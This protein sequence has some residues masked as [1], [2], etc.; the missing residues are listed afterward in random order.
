MT[1]E[2]HFVIPGPPVPKARARKGLFGNWYTPK[3]TRNYEQHV[4]MT[5]LA[6]RQRSKTRWPLDGRYQVKA[7]I[8]FS[9]AR[10][11]DGDNVVKSLLDGANTILWNDDK[12]VA[13]RVTD[14]SIDRDNPRVEVTVTILPEIEETKGPIS[15]RRRDGKPYAR[16]ARR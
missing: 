7:S 5:A 1:Q 15:G 13:K 14:D 11:R 10:T 3:K 6:A 9:D 8:Y 16:A 2:L 4:G 12:Q